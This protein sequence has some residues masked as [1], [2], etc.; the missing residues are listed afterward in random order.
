VLK[1]PGIV[2]SAA[3][4]LVALG[5]PVH[6]SPDLTAFDTND[7][8]WGCAGDPG[9]AVPPAHCTNLR[10][11]GNTGLIKVF[12]PDPRWPQESISSDPKSD[13]RP[14]PHDPDATDG[15]RWSPSPGVWVCHHR[16]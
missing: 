10:S 8:T 1:K 9:V 16:P 2:V 13:D 12:E 15:T 6:A 5:S 14:C 4:A 11:R 3:A 7:A